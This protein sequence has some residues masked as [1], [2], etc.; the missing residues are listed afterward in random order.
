MSDDE[1][2]G[3]KQS[4][5]MDDVLEIFWSPASVF[6]RVRE[7]TGWKYVWFWVI[8]TAVIGVA[9]GNLIRPYLEAQS[10]QAMAAAAASGKV[11]PPE[12]MAVARS[13]AF[14]S[15]MFAVPFSVLLG[16][17]VGGLFVVL[18]SKTFGSALR[19]RQ[20]FT[21]MALS[22]G[23]RALALLAVAAQ[24]AFMDD[25]KARS[26]ADLSV[27]PGRLTDP[28]TTSPLLQTFLSA[29][30]LFTLWQYVIIAIG[31]SVMVRVSRA[32]GALVSLM[33]W[34]LGAALTL[35]PGL[36]ASR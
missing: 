33:T 5:L 22:M 20:A 11:V 6:E 10:L 25:S 17:L 24:A 4:G 3:G 1:V 2:A 28:A 31:V 32:Q 13:V 19:F 9:T 29:N 27:G 18:A 15:Y 26:M 35:I 16:S 36:L 12:S 23:P 14:Y 21:V 30:D 7:R 34:V 8:V